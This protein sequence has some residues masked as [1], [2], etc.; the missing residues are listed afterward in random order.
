MNITCVSDLHGHFP[1]LQ[2]GDLLIVAGDLTKSET[3]EEYCDFMEWFLD[4]RYQK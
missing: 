3:L 1:E 4:Q 2:G